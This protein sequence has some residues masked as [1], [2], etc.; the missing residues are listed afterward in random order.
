MMRRSGN[1][2][3]SAKRAGRRVL[4]QARRDRL[5]HFLVNWR[6][7]LPFI[8]ILLGITA[9]TAWLLP[10]GT[11]RGFVL[12]VL[13]SLTVGM[14]LYMAN[15]LSGAG[16]RASGG[17]A[18]RFTIEALRKLDERRWVVFDHVAFADYD[19]DHVVI[20]PGAIFAVETKWRTTMPRN[21]DLLEFSSQAERSADR[22]RLLLKSHG[23]KREVA[24]I[25]VL[26]GPG[27]RELLP[28][29]GRR[30]KGALVVGGGHGETWRRVLE[31]RATGFELD[32]SAVQ[33]VEK[34]VTANDRHQAS[35]DKRR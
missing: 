25:V 28:P 29:E 8:M 4:Q 12:G 1:G 20:G 26:W 6:F 18:E 2:A 7:Y 3:R 16:N 34:Y 14:V 33:A 35:V 9:G 27:H 22:L 30:L 19:I 11:W 17:E 13:V 23:V 32:F 15:M 5:R 10:P 31:G 21:R 24:S